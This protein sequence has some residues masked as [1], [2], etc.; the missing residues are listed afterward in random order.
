MKTIFVWLLA[1]S[2]LLS[3]CGPQLEATPKVASSASICSTGTEF[4]PGDKVDLGETAEFSAVLDTSGG[5]NPSA[6]MMVIL[7]ETEF[8]SSG[9]VLPKDGKVSIISWGTRVVVRVANCGGRYYYSAELAEAVDPNRDTICGAGFAGPTKSWPFLDR[10]LLYRPGNSE[11]VWLYTGSGDPT[12]MR[13]NE[14]QATGSGLV[15]R[16]LDGKTV[17][18]EVPVTGGKLTVVIKNCSQVLYYNASWRAGS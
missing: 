5:S 14:G 15:K 3:A 6:T 11:E 4:T 18:M 17:Q 9:G 10:I 2:W 7:P 13:F 12:L 8:P 1:A 16:P